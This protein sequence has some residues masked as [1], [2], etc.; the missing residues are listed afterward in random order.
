MFAGFSKPCVLPRGNTGGV[1]LVVG[2]CSF[3]PVNNYICEDLLKLL[4]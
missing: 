3:L 1:I 4:I 2:R